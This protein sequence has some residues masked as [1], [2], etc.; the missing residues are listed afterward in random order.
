MTLLR[1][2]Q[3]E[4]YYLVYKY[5]HTYTCYLH[6]HICLWFQIW[7]SFVSSACLPF[8]PRQMYEKK[9]NHFPHRLHTSRLASQVSR[10]RQRTIFKQRT[11]LN[12]PPSTP[13]PAPPAPSW[14][15]IKS[16]CPAQFDRKVRNQ[17]ETPN[18]RFFSYN[19]Q[20]GLASSMLGAGVYGL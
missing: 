5:L 12:S 10:G 15:A 9:T 6:I 16:H 1:Q 8:E 20:W 7:L 2:P 18:A 11:L 13:P 17:T 4:A 3:K 19:E 14:K